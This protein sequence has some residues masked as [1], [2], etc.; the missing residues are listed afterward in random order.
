MEKAVTNSDRID[1]A[2]SG[3]HIL[4]GSTPTKN[5]PVEQ[6]VK[7]LVPTITQPTH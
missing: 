2:A 3:Q 5:Q 7:P 4:I 1:N 6:Y